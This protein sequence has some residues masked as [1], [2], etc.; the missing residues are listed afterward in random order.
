MSTETTKINED[1]E[2]ITRTDT[3]IDSSGDTVTETVTETNGSTPAPAK[4][5]HP[6]PQHFPELRPHEPRHE[7]REAQLAPQP[8]PV[9]PVVSAPAPI[10]DPHTVYDGSRYQPEHSV[11]VRCGSSN[12]ARGYVVDY[13]DKF[14]QI[15]FAPKRVTLARLNSLL[16]L[17]PFLRLAKLDALACRDCGAVLLVIDPAELRRVEHR[18]E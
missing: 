7:P 9:A 8:V 10:I 1:T 6:Q 17:R 12:L 18:R 4:P 13:S 15:N 16:T 2:S 14:G 3:V 11:C 5:R